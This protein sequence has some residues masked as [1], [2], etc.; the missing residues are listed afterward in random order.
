MDRKERRKSPEN[1]CMH[2][3]IAFNLHNISI[4]HIKT[5]DT[6]T[7][8]HFSSSSLSIHSLDKYLLISYYLSVIGTGNR[9]TCKTDVVPVLKDLTVQHEIKHDMIETIV[10]SL[11]N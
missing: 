7:L 4:L 3:G 5:L 1:F 10:A 11:T 2:D 9:W 8:S 6:E